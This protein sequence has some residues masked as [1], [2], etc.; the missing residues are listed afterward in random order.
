LDIVNRA[1][2][3]PLLSRAAGCDPAAPTTAARIRRGRPAARALGPAFGAGLPGPTKADKS[4]RK[5]TF[6]KST[7]GLWRRGGQGGGPGKKR[8][9][10]EKPR[11]DEVQ[12]I[13]GGGIEPDQGVKRK[14]AAGKAEIRPRSG[15]DDDEVLPMQ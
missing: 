13:S 5:P 8:K 12:K 1:G 10:R 3:R 9:S 4:R 6:K 14:S 2:D 15:R 11:N 7:G